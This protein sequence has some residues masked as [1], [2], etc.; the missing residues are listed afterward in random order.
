MLGAVFAQKNATRIIFNGGLQHVG[1]Y[2]ETFQNIQCFEGCF[3]TS[4]TAALSLDFNLLYQVYSKIDRLSFLYGAGINQKSWTEK[5][6]SSNGAGLINSPYSFRNDNTYLV[7]F[8]EST[9]ISTVVKKS[10]FSLGPY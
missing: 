3:L 4:Q 6:L 10:N 2:E 9:M 5:G 1:M 8:M 7:F